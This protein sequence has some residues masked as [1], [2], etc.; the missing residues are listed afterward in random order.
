MNIKEEFILNI[1]FLF[2]MVMFCLFCMGLALVFAFDCTTYQ[3]GSQ[4]LYCCSNGTM[5]NCQ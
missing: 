1:V 3:I 5:I 2:I 4:I